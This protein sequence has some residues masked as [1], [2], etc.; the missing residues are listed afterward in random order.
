M[1]NKK[2]LTLIEIFISVTIILFFVFV[3]NLPTRRS[4]HSDPKQR[5]CLRNLRL[6]QGAVEMYNMDNSIMMKK[7]N[8]KKLI[9]GKY[10]KEEPEKT[11]P[12]CYYFSVGDLSKDEGVIVCKIHGDSC[13]RSVLDRSE[14]EL[15]NK[16]DSI[17]NIFSN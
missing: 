13:N 8:I 11:D 5:G 12:S 3:A 4:G 1:N 15:L 6:L 14:K 2:G 10:I 16:H 17:F 9:E 7:L